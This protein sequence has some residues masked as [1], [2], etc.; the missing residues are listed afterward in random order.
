VTSSNASALG[1]GPGSGVPPQ[2][3]GRIIGVVKAYSTR[4]GGGP[5]P[6]ELFDETGE[7]IRQRGR[8]FGTTTGRP[9]RVGWLDLV[10]L[11]YAAMISGATELC[12][13]LL[14]VLAGEP[15]LKLATGYGTPEGMTVRF[16]ADGYG[17]AEATPIY[18]MLGGFPEDIS[19]ARSLDELPEPARA[20]VQR[21]EEFVG[22]RVGMISVGPDREQTII[23]S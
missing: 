9:R 4:V 5:M 19:G 20:Y 18:E 2:A 23:C 15:E 21:I 6:T 22:V 11:K 13:T 14:D 17:L 1:I 8:E 7:A 10:A 3:V 12:I 16:I